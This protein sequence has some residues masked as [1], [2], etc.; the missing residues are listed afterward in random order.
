MKRFTELFTRLDESN[1]TNDKLAALRD[2]FGEAEPQSAAWALWFLMGN[3][4]RAPVKTKLLREWAS[5]LSEFPL[6]MVEECYDH[7]GD[8]AET[9]A[10]ILPVSDDAGVDWPLWRLVEDKVV[11]L[12]DW[13][14]PLQFQL[15]R[16]AWHRLPPAQ[17]FVYNKL[18]TGGFRV[19]VS[20]TLVVRALAECAGVERAE[21]EHRLM[22]SWRPSAEAFAQ[23]ISR[24]SA[25]EDNPARP[26]P[27]FLACPLEGAPADL[28]EPA[29]WRTEWKWD[30]IRAQLI[31]RAGQVVLWSRGEEMIAERF[32]EVTTLAA[33]LPDGVVLDGELLAWRDDR[34]LPFAVLQKRIG[35]TKLSARVLAE[36]P[37]AFLA[38]DC[39]EFKGE[40]LRERT[41]RERVTLLGKALVGFHSKD[42]SL[43]LGEAVDFDTWESLAEVRATSRERGVEGVMLKRWDSPYRVGRVKGDWWK[44]KIDPYSVDAVMV[45]AQSGHGRRSG[46]YTD[47]TFAIW[48]GDELV[49]F[50]KAYSGLTDAEIVEVDRW[51]RRHTVSRHGP[52]RVVN[53]ELVFELH[54]EGI[55]ESTRHK[56]GLAVRFPRMA[57]WRKDKPASEADTLETVRALLPDSATQS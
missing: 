49:T 41:L 45:A 23:L 33:R 31:K 25:P 12:S 55:A 2:Y 5:Q 48:D 18:I 51:V 56:S 16:E 40:D 35:R 8:L 9:L 57:R 21:M 39:L 36:S 37:A 7:V 19:G 52:V 4:M 44:W 6:W 26:Y 10:L 15:V 50:A 1:R 47:Y 43:L 38:Y 20:R 14:G 42:S 53:P 17:R 22:G 46:L 27:F 32:P 11:A 28:G 13:D 29:D 24:E 54:F 30:G 3:R 34:P